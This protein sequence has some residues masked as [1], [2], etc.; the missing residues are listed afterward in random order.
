MNP[1]DQNDPNELDQLIAVAREARQF[2]YAPYSNFAVGAVVESRDG[3]L[4]TGCNVEN[5][6][7]GLTLCAERVA[8][9]K[10]ISEGARDLL[11]VVVIA[12]T[13]RPIPPCGACR[14]LILE[15]AGPEAAVV[16]ANLAG[17]HIVTTSSALL[18]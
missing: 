17:D 12:D 14:Q 5:A 1:N 13:R 3:R 8:L 2:A 6:S 4:F 9:G 7:Y 11:R 18:P 10:A 15:L 16:L